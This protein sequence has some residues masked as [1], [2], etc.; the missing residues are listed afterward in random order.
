[1]LEVI[2]VDAAEGSEVAFE[3]GYR[4]AAHLVKRAKGFVSMQLVRGIEVPNRYR[5][6][7]RW[8]TLDSHTRELRESAD[9]EALVKLTRP[10]AAG[11]A[12]VQHDEFVVDE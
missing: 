9:H 4:E 3:A 2:E 5:V 11:R 7:I 10:H 1:V 6:R 12:V 8:L